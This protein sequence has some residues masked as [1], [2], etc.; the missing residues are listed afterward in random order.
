MDTTHL[1]PA[2]W[3]LEMVQGLA[4][5]HFRM[6]FESLPPT[7]SLN[8]RTRS[9]QEYI[10]KPVDTGPLKRIYQLQ[11]ISTVILQVGFTEESNED[12]SN[13]LVWVGYRNDSRNQIRYE[14]F[15]DIVENQ[16]SERIVFRMARA[17]VLYYFLAAG[18]IDVID[19]YDTFWTDFRTACSWVARNG[20][21]PKATS[22]SLQMA[23]EKPG[24]ENT[25]MKQNHLNLVLEDVRN[26]CQEAK[27]TAEKQGKHANSEPGTLES[28]RLKRHKR[29]P[30]PSG[31]EVQSVNSASNKQDITS[32]AVQT[33]PNL[34]EGALTNCGIHAEAGE[35]ESLQLKLRHK[36]PHKFYDI[37]ETRSHAF[38]TENIRLRA[39]K[40][41]LSTSVNLLQTQKDYDQNAYSGLKSKHDQLVHDE[42]T[43]RQVHE[44]LK[45]TCKLLERRIIVAETA[46][47]KYQRN[48]QEEQKQAQ[49]AET[50]WK[51]SMASLVRLRQHMRTS[52]GELDREY[53]ELQE[54]K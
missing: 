41:A 19:D 23:G 33:G 9:D 21:H 11:D 1:S 26:E 53:G 43:V 4:W 8:F 3:C 2:K 22:H 27:T 35:T 46:A 34:S 44:Q 17:L 16:C 29:N 6:D 48:L 38:M 52:A 32:K 18:Y 7:S 31:D 54:D 39:E 49:A 36:A 28:P 10:K 15:C 47:A 5:A 42:E 20:Q 30:I 51:K 24:S 13:C 40:E 14:P 12:D 25:S 45:A 50:K 37:L